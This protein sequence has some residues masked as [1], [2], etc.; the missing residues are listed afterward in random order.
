MLKHRLLSGGILIAA[1]VLFTFW[2][3]TVSSI[4]FLF[5][6]CCLLS[7]AINEFFALT[8]ELGF[9]GYPFLTTLWAVCQ[10][11]VIGAVHMMGVHKKGHVNIAESIV[12]L[13]F[14]LVLFFRAFTESDFKHGVRNLTASLAAFLYL[15]WSLAFIVKIYFFGDE[16][17]NTWTVAAILSNHCYE[18]R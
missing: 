14:V 8:R 5:F 10:F 4:L 15:G 11:A 13:A 2:D 3:S 6:S 9:P 18:M 17:L 16:L 1:F 12:I 7:F